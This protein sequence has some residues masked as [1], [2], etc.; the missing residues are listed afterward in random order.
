MRRFCSLNCWWPNMTS[1]FRDPVKNIENTIH[2]FSYLLFQSLRLN[3]M[4][5]GAVTANSSFQSGRSWPSHWPTRR[6]SSWPRS[7][8]PSTSC[9]TPKSGPSPPSSF[10][11]RR[12]TRPWNTMERVSSGVDPTK[13][14]F[15]LVSDFC[16]INQ[17]WQPIYKDFYGFAAQGPRTRKM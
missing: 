3:S 9:P 16:H 7:T 5:H 17:I 1:I 12:Q 13:L 8:P 10:T 14:H 11:R 15:S 6:T 4:H 2:F